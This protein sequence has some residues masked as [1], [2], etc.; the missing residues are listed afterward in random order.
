VST[1]VDAPSEIRVASWDFPTVEHGFGRRERPVASGFRLVRSRQVHGDDVLVVDGSSASP[2]GDADGMV[3]ATRGVAV[4][5]ATADCVPVLL[6]APEAGVVAAVHAGWRGS[7]L[8]IVPRAI[9]LLR[10]RFG[11]EPASVHAALGPSIGG[12]CYEIEREIAARFAD[13][14]GEGMW[15]AWKAGAADKG[16]LDLRTVNERLLVEAGVPAASV[17]HAGPCTACGGE[18]LASY[19]KQGPRAGR[20]VS[21]IGLR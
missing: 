15:T 17:S 3:T 18:D 8:G 5:I 2:A 19:R 7:L 20:Q 6:A 12:C 10:D 4:G 13:R 21:W 1:D 16:T 9:D 14:F 11:V